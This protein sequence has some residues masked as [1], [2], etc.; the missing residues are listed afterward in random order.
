MSSEVVPVL[1]PAKEDPSSPVFF[2]AMRYLRFGDFILDRHRQELFRNGTR[3]KLHGKTYQVLRALLERPGE[4]VTR[5]ELRG[6]LWPSGTHVH[7][8]ANVNTTVNKLRQ[9]L[10]DSPNDP[11]YIE[12]IPRRGY[13]FVATVEPSEAPAALRRAHPEAAPP[14]VEQGFSATDSPGRGTKPFSTRTIV[15]IAALIAAGMLLGAGIATFWLT[16]LSQVSLLR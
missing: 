13:C 15:G 9:A 12:T 6:R 11:L 8:D 4:V 7:F 16:R 3:L 5:E 2:D 14:L 1:E 10:G